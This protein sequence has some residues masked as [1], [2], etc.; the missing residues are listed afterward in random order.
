MKKFVLLTFMLLSGL[1]LS[2][3]DVQTYTYKSYALR[4]AIGSILETQVINNEKLSVNHYPNNK[5]YS[6]IIS[7]KEVFD[8]FYG[9]QLADGRYYYS[10]KYTHYFQNPNL[11]NKDYDKTMDMV[12]YTKTPLSSFLYNNGL[13]ANSN[14]FDESKTIQITI[15]G[16]PTDMFIY[17]IKNKE[18]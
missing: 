2:A 12:I 3:Q 11:P 9:G 14:R 18:D 1:A 6:I 8:C 7:Q 17:P 16:I 4:Y 10:G 5:K 15:D 13:D